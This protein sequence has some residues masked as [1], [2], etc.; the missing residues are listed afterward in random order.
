M[1]GNS[2]KPLL[3]ET[4]KNACFL[5][6]CLSLCLTLVCALQRRQ[7]LAAAMCPFSPAWAA[8]TFPLVSSCIV[9]LLYKLDY[10]FWAARPNLG[11][12]A[13]PNLDDLARPNLD[14]LDATD[15]ADLGG[16]GGGG[17]G[18]GG[19]DGG[20]GGGGGGGEASAETIRW[21]SNQVAV[22]LVPLTLIIVPTLDLLWMLSIPQV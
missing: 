22:I 21:L 9:S 19:G 12:L 1:V 3:G 4:G 20:G 2:H 13:R 18:G 5:L 16:S 17:G 14:D 15:L 6:N 7:R 11:D 8:L 10:D